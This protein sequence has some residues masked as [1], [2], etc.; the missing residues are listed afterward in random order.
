[1]YAILGTLPC[2]LIV[3]ISIVC[4]NDYGA[5][6]GGIITVHGL[7]VKLPRAV[8]SKALIAEAE[9]RST[10]K[11]TCRAWEAGPHAQQRLQKHVRSRGGARHMRSSG[12]RAEHGAEATREEEEGKES[13]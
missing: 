9:P 3:A 8:A 6:S 13:C 12:R 7:Q 11:T 10:G 5:W 4:G 2:P 1:M